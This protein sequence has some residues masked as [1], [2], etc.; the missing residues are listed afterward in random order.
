MK[1]LF[2]FNISVRC[3]FDRIYKS[4]FYKYSAALLLFIGKRG[5]AHR[6]ICRKVSAIKEKGAAHR[7][8]YEQMSIKEI[9]KQ[10]ESITEGY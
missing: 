5:A 10:I 4:S 8:I 3:T 7:N 9:H 2:S 6:Y 1:V